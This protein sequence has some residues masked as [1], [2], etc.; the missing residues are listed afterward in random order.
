MGGFGGVIFLIE[1]FFGF[2]NAGGRVEK[3]WSFKPLGWLQVWKQTW[4]ASYFKPLMFLVLRL[5]SA[6]TTENTS[7]GNQPKNMSTLDGRL[8]RWTNFSWWIIGI[9]FRW[10][11]VHRGTDILCDV[12]LWFCSVIPVLD[13]LL[14][15]LDEDGLYIFDLM[16]GKVQIGRNNWCQLKAH[17]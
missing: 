16:Y 6:R 14:P 10:K 9:R 7:S 4:F 1:K 12:S 8:T 15:N 11:L 3:S 5:L 2:L 13:L 17:R